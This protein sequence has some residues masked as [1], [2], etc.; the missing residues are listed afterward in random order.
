MT[1]T[2]TF[3]L[4]L[5]NLFLR[6]ERSATVCCFIKQSQDYNGTNYEKVSVRV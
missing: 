6:N 1:R 5:M 3:S 4:P 2:L